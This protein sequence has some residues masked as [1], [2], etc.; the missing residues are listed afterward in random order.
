[1]YKSPEFMSR[2]AA[3]GIDVQLFEHVLMLRPDM[4]TLEDGVRIDDYARI[5]G[6]LGTRIGRY[7]HVASFAS[8]LG[9][10]ETIVGAYAGLAQG[11]KVVTGGGHPFWEHFPVAPP[12]DD[13]YHIMRGKVVIG[14]YAL[15]AANA[16]VLPG[17][18]V[19][20]GAV[21]AACAVAT[22]D[23]PPWTIV[24]GQP[25]KPVRQRKNFLL[26]R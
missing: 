14:D 12:E 16:V 13:L 23:V 15:I 18:T 1:M 25:A 19:G 4:I 9:G 7:T 2:L 22:R 26:N 8:I 24:A 10:G 21:V 20:E 5:E 17:V 11:A 3:V 6:G